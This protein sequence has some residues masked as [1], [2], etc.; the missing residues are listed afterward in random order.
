MNGSEESTIWSAIDKQRE[1]TS[2]ILSQLTELKT[3]ITTVITN[4]AKQD[5]TIEVLEKEGKPNW[6]AISGIVSVVMSIAITLGGLIIGP[7][8]ASIEDSEVKIVEQDKELRELSDKLL[9]LVERSRWTKDL[10]Q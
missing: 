6:L 4:Q 2:G 3:L 5:A 1:T 8:K 10:S 9:V 7:M